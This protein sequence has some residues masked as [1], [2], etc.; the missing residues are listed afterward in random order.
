MEEETAGIV[1]INGSGMMKAGFVGDG[2][3]R[4]V[5]PTI[6]GR[7]RHH[8]I[9]VGMRN[10]KWGYVGDESQS[11]CG[12]LQLNLPIEYGI[13]TNWDDIELV[14]HHTFYNE[15]RIDP[16]EHSHLMSEKPFNPKIN[17][18]KMV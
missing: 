5:F 1:I 2:A 15:L 9:M 14:W 6:V 13:I 10:K 11:K 4:A 7:P 18:Q 8:G 17:R 3:P 16:T 12:I